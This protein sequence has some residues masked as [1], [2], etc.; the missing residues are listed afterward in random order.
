[1]KSVSSAAR[2]RVASTKSVESTFDTK[3]NVMSLPAEVPERLVGHDRSEVGAADADVDDVL[4]RL[5]G[6]A[7]PLARADPVGEGRH[8]VEDR[9]DLGHHV[10]PVDDEGGVPGHAQRDVQDGAVLRD[11]DVLAAEHH[12]P[13]LLEVRL[14]GQ[15]EE[16]PHGLVGH[17]VLRVVEVEP[18]GLRPQPLAAVRILGEQVAQV[19][20]A[21]LRVVTLE[22]GPRRPLP[23]RGHLVRARHAPSP[24]LRPFASADPHWAVAN[25]DANVGLAHRSPLSA[26]RAI[27]SL[28]SLIGCPPSGRTRGA[29][30]PRR[31]HGR[32]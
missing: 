12:V 14:L 31:P 5:A 30:G 2:S 19:A 8:P 15:L 13:A 20:L 17:A 28:R 11:V 21:D 32:G 25:A 4:D 9:V 23:Q 22:R 26:A 16:Q 27:R 18:D 3:R 24:R 1:M 6:V 10:D 29:R 7:L